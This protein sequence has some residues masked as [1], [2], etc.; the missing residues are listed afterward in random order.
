M[1]HQNAEIERKEMEMAVKLVEM[2]QQLTS[3][4][5]NKRQLEFALET[6]QKKA[7]LQE[8]E[9][10]VCLESEDRT[11]LVIPCGHSF[12]AD[13]VDKLKKICPTCGTKFKKKP[14][15]KVYF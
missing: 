3:E 13:C 9:C 10:A 14:T 4:K 2:E 12:C 8:K 7:K 6:E 1:D 15:Q 5:G 11:W